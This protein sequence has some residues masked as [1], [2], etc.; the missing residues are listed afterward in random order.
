MENS[1]RI[2]IIYDFDGTLAPGNMQEYDFIPA[3]GK[4]NEEFWQ[5]SSAMAEQ[6]DGDTILAY[7]YHMIKE[8]KNK[9]VSL[10][11]EA[12]RESGSKVSL[13]EG[14]REWFPRINAYAL[15]RGIELE[16]YINSSGIKEMIEGTPIAHEFKKIYA[17]SF[18]YDVDGVAF[19]PSVVVNYTTKTQFLFKIN[20]GIESVADNV[21]V[22]RYVPEEKRRIP[23]KH[24]IYIGDGLTDIPCMRLVKQM[25]GYS[26][27]VYNTSSEKKIE[28]IRKLI[29][30]NRVDFVA[31]A[32]YTNH[33]EI[34]LLV[35]KI[36]D[37]IY[38]DN[39][40]SNMK[41][42]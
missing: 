10:R 18:F 32:H 20:K 15:Q 21:Q 7:L 11:K 24:M 41:T 14:V 19:W 38:I 36:I 3:V 27:A 39:S 4:D 8:A 42:Y 29:D 40:L 30:D 23:F 5:E 26:I 6:Q 12:F 28:E 25:G 34:D 33:S 1:L 37:K 31:P 13:F 22:N 16:H 2:A 17:C 9:N 35:K